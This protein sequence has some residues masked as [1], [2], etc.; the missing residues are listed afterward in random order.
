MI[1]KI[2]KLQRPL[3]TNEEFPT[4]MAYT[5]GK[6]NMAMIPMGEELIE[7]LF[8]DEVKLYAKAR[9]VNGVLKVKHLVEEQVW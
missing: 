7:E 2:W 9:V 1:N 6:K 5:K 8:G 3:A 4:V